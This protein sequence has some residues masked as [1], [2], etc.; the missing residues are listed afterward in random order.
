MERRVFDPKTMVPQ[1]TD[2]YLCRKCKMRLRMYGVIVCSP[3]YE[4]LTFRIFR[5]HHYE[6]K[7]FRDMGKGG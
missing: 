4:R 5:G 7:E 3:C 2:E 6:I 1:N